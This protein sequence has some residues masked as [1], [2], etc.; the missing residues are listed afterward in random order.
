MAIVNESSATVGTERAR[1]QNS[2]LY[3]RS[4]P[5]SPTSSALRRPAH[6]AMPKLCRHCSRVVLTRTSVTASTA[7]ASTRE[8]SDHKKIIMKL[9]G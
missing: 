7:K 3:F 2:A 9:R 5:P 8:D 6:R 1:I 4:Q